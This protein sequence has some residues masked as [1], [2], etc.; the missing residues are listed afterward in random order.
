MMHACSELRLAED[1]ETK[2]EIEY[3]I[4]LSLY[5]FHSNSVVCSVSDTKPDADGRDP[6]IS[7]EDGEI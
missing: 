1:G 7:S 5:L 6:F 4:D 2:K 3:R